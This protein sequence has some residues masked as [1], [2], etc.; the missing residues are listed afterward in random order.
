MYEAYG[1]YRLVS[2]IRWDPT[3]MV[4]RLRAFYVGKQASTSGSGS[5]EW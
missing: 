2:E 4:R 5:G 3:Y 1:Q